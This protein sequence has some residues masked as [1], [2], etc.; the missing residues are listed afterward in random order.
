[1][2][3]WKLLRRVLKALVSLIA[4][5]LLWY[6]VPAYLYTQSKMAIPEWMIGLAIF[7]SITASLGEFFE[8]K[9]IGG[10]FLSISSA[11]EVA[12]IYLIAEGGCI[13]VNFRG[14][15]ITL[16]FKPLLY[17]LMLPPLIEVIK[18]IWGTIERSVSE[19]AELVEYIKS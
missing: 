19:R 1:M 14:M 2:E 8:R 3:R 18:H 12:F 7:V 11:S 16:E 5:L 10:I 6:V 15:S 9:G 4:N 17:L 13:E